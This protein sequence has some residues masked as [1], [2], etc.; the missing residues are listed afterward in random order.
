MMNHMG[1]LVLGESD[2]GQQR[3]LPQPENTKLTQLF[4]LCDL[5][6][7]SYSSQPQALRHLQVITA[8]GDT[9]RGCCCKRRKSGTGS[10]GGLQSA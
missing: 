4:K 6:N 10:S 3:T 7:C 5:T 9:R 1:S 2:N 8:D